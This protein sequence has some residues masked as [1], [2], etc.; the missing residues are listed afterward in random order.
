MAE[1]TPEAREYL[2]GYLKQVC[3]LA[4]GAG[5]DGDDIA[6]GLRDH[7]TA[8]TVDEAGPLVTLEVLRRILAEIGSPEA[9]IET[10]ASWKAEPTVKQ[11]SVRH[12][13]PPPVPAR[14]SR[15][16]RYTGWS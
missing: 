9:I 6:A 3:A 5:E 7:V 13:V 4:R 8:K 11:T 12:S 16:T 15:S 10:G 2:D 1:W 14:K